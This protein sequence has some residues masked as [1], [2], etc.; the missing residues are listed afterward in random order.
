MV[1]AVVSLA[2][3]ALRR[4]GASPESRYIDIV[5]LLSLPAIALAT[6]EAGR[7]LAR[8]FGRVAVGV[9]GAVVVGF[10]VVQVIALDH[11]VSN[12]PFVG[13][14]RPRVLATAL[15]MRNHEPIAS[16]NIFGIPYLT[17]PSTATIARFDRNG[18]LPALDVS[19]ADVLTAR[20]YVET[21]IGSASAY[22]EGVA[23]FARAKRASTGAA[24]APG[25]LT[26]APATPRARPVATLHL[27]AA[28]SFRVASDRAATASMSLVEGSTGGRP[29]EFSTGPGDGTAVGI[30]RAT[31]LE[32]TLPGGT[33]STLCGLG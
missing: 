7:A 9:C 19:R 4:A 18:E 27:P 21:V 11:E 33:T 14:M 31:D 16:T 10:L 26:V 17:E 25:C 23:H 20:E 24:T 32:L 29:R 1:G 5:V 28:G 3:T 13:E 22:P 2:L 6:Q 8:R 15:I 12:E 30:S